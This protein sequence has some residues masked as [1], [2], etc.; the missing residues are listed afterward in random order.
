MPHVPKAN[1]KAPSKPSSETFGERH[2][3]RMP[4]RK[5]PF[6]ASFGLTFGECHV[7][8][9]ID[10]ESIPESVA[11]EP[12][13]PECLS[14]ETT[15]GS[16]RVSHVSRVASTLDSRALS[17]CAACPECLSQS[18]TLDTFRTHHVSR[19]L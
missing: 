11:R 14:R 16:L 18:I 6:G 13:V 19:D 10:R 7:S 12:R 5:P 1:S 8:R 15:F 3:S 2:L 9:V 17:G 4:P